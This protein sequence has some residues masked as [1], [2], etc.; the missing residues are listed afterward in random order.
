MR[1]GDPL[2]RAFQAPVD[3]HASADGQ[4]YMF[5]YRREEESSEDEELNVMELRPR[6][7]ELYSQ[8]RERAEEILLLERDIS[9]EDNLNKLSLQYG[10]KVADIKRVNNLF[11]EQDMYALKSI[12]IPV[13]KHGLLTKAIS[14]LKN[15]QQR[16][17]NDIASSNSAEANIS[18]TP[19]VQEYTNYLKEVDSDIE[20]LIQSTVPSEEVL[21]SGSWISR[22]RGWRSRYLGSYGADWG[23]QWWNAV[24]AMLLIGIVLPIFY[25]VYFKT[26]H[27]SVSVV[28][29][30]VG[31]ITGSFNTS[32]SKG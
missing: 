5:G 10:C 2:P 9:H 11:Q 13:K 30:I 27:N 3:V 29:N 1:R 22:Q 28:Y 4:V 19:Q 18:G 16:T 21:S 32:K 23:I 17:C 12:R 8:E 31:N 14:E 25:V 26:Q 15:P 20:R 6:S 24:I 7:R